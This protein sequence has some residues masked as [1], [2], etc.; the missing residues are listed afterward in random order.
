LKTVVQR[1]FIDRFKTILRHSGNV[2]RDKRSGD[3]SRL[4]ARLTNVERDLYDKGRRGAEEY[5]MWKAGK[6]G[7]HSSI[8]LAVRRGVARRD[9]ADPLTTTATAAHADSCHRDIH[10][11]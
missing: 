10:E 6:L 9:A 11:R 7:T 2:Q 3:F 5:G 1:T 8:Y 4:M